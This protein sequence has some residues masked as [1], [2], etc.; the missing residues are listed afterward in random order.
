[1]GRRIPTLDIQPERFGQ[2]LILGNE[3]VYQEAT[4]VN[5]IYQTVG[6][7]CLRLSLHP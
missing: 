1:M 5:P 6:E 2:T 4:E 3:M 7:L